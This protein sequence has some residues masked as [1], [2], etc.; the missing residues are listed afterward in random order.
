MIAL[1][2]HGMGRTPASQLLLAVRLRQHGIRTHLF[3][4]STLASFK[5]TVGR[6]AARAAFTSGNGP[7]VLIGHS[8]VAS[9]CHF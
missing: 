3:G 5:G 8:L 2:V 7:Y 9:G 1:L 6:L 4:Y